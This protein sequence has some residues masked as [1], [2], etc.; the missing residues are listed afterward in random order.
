MVRTF[1]DQVGD[2]ERRYGRKATQPTTPPVAWTPENSLFVVFIGICD[3][4]GTYARWDDAD[5][6]PVFKRY[7]ELVNRLHG[8]GARN[9]L[10]MNVPAFERA[11]GVKNRDMKR[12][13]HAKDYYNKFVLRESERLGQVNG[14]VRSM[15]FD[16]DEVFLKALNNP[17]AYP[18]TAHITNLDGFCVG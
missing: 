1:K 17:S 6:H 7:T 14:D 12:N 11:P 13:I 18:E 8:E 9:V 16:T 4:A 3:V 2:F 5:Y 10:F 15:Y